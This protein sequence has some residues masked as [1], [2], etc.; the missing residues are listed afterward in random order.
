MGE[1][2]SH[3]WPGQGF[4]GAFLK[5]PEKEQAVL[6]V[7]LGGVVLLAYLVAASVYRT[8]SI[9]ETTALVA[10]YVAFGGLTYVAATVAPERSRLRLPLT[11]ISDQALL[12]AL[13][14]VGGQVALPLLWVV[15]WF[16]VG[17]GCRY[18]QRMLA[19]SCAVALSG[20][21]G[22]MLW[23]PWWHANL[24][25]GLGV[26]LS[27]AA[28]SIYLAVLVRRLEKQAAT[29]PLTGLSNRVRLEH[30][31]ART[32]AIRGPEANQAAL[33]LVDLDGFKEVNDAH[34]HAVGDELLRSFAAAL[35]SGMRRGDT[36]ARLGG[37]EFVLLAHQIHDRAG[38]LT[39]ATQIHAIL[40]TLCTVAGHPVI[41][42]GSIGVCM[43]A[44]ESGAAPL[45][46]RTLMR[47]AD[48]AMYRAKSRG[49]GQTVFAEAHEMR[50]GA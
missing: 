44:Q 33:L 23:H 11:T 28:T 30:A 47:A 31:I 17:A 14:A 12:I 36:L 19:L 50:P 49:N 48:S 18:G 27:L 24:L 1:A 7:S 2:H 26:A 35:A 13:L 15:F 4:L 10:L 45:D 41:V 40:S 38:A 6:R 42:S 8:R 46:A 43:L 22:L 5:T 39:I 3:S 25:A 9:Y 20:L 34:G 16:L 37:D 32:L 21:A 29:D